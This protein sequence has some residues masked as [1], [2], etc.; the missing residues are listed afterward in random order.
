MA[1]FHPA[2]AL[3]LAQEDVGNAWFGQLTEAEQKAALSA[4]SLREGSL[5]RATECVLPVEL[6]NFT[7]F[8]VCVSSDYAGDNMIVKSFFLT[9]WLLKLFL[10]I[11]SALGVGWADIDVDNVVA[12]LIRGMPPEFGDGFDGAVFGILR[13]L[14]RDSGDANAETEEWSALAPVQ[15]YVV[16]ENRLVANPYYDVRCSRNMG[17]QISVFNPRLRRVSVLAKVNEEYEVKSYHSSPPLAVLQWV[18]KGVYIRTWRSENLIVSDE[19][20]ATLLSTHAH[21][22]WSDAIAQRI[23]STAT[24]ECSI[25]IPVQAELKNVRIDT[26]RYAIAILQ[27]RAQQRGQT[28]REVGGGM[29]CRLPNPKRLGFVWEELPMGDCS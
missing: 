26:A 17:M 2:I 21:A 7:L 12:H 14:I 6:R 23:V 20:L 15:N 18:L 13:R 28:Y 10:S 3:P 16:Q 24:N 19:L 25:L 22:T 5:R 4:Q 27:Y 9:L 1:A 8:R 11:L 29:M